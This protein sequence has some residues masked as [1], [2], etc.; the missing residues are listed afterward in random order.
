[1]SSTRYSVLS[2][3]YS[4]SVPSN[5]AEG[6]ARFSHKEFGRFLNT[7][8]GSLVE[9]ETQLLIAQE[10]HYIDET[11]TGSLLASTAE[12]GRL[13]NG[14]RNSLKLRLEDESESLD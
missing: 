3:R 10:L 2:T 9:V 12:I 11:S 14:L 1:M 6:Q 8:R 7:A 5:I 13:L 4:V